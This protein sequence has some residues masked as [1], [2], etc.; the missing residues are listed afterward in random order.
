[1]PW[2]PLAEVTWVDEPTFESGLDHVLAPQKRRLSLV[3]AV[4]FLVMRRRGLERAFAFDPRFEE[5]GFSL[6]A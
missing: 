5:E 6:V 3:D 1:L 4:S 2:W